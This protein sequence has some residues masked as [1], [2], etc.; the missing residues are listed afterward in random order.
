M[1]EQRGPMEIEQI[2]DED[3]RAH[4]KETYADPEAAGRF[5]DELIETR[6]KALKQVTEELNGD[7]RLAERF[8][9]N[10][11][12]FLNARKLLGPL[13]QILARGPTATYR[14]CCEFS[15]GEFTWPKSSWSPYSNPPDQV[16]VTQTFEQPLTSTGPSTLGTLGDTGEAADRDRNAQTTTASRMYPASFASQATPHPALIPH[17]VAGNPRR[18][19]RIPARPSSKGPA[20]A[21]IPAYTRS[22]RKRQDRPVT[23]EVAGSSPVAPVS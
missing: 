22:A 17:E 8:A 1:S 6:R 3:A 12:G 10:P 5:F 11:I 9:R 23:P 13:D 2:S 19:P 21:G 4:L 20:A 7:E 18:H 16:N 15:G 14:A